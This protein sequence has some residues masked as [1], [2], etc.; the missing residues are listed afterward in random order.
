MILSDK[1]VTMM[2]NEGKIKILPFVKKNLNPC[3]FDLTL[4]SQFTLFKK[5]RTLDSRK[6]VR[7]E[8][9][10]VINTE[11]E[12]FEIQ[13]R[14]FVLARTVE[15]I[16]ISRDIAAT[17]QGRSSIARL[18]IVVLAAGLVNPGSGASKPVPMVLEVFCQNTSPVK[19][20]PG[21]KIVQIIFHKLTTPAERGYDEI[22]GSR[23]IGQE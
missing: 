15:K 13:P 8:D 21:T 2:V 19:L 12:A 17:L 23:F 4:S 6:A 7:E 22:E 16:A 18:G 1:D 10:E 14:Q 5:G 11:G 3:S 9:V 20:Y